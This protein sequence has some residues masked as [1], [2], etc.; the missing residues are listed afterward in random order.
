MPGVSGNPGGRPRSKALSHAAREVLQTG[1]PTVAER[2][3]KKIA[4]QAISGDVRAAEF[5]RDSSEGRPAQ[6]VEQLPADKWDTPEHRAEVD[7]A[8][9]EVYGFRWPDDENSKPQ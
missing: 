6:R 1:N 2:I 7:R 8:V 5:L 4:D 9:F 3:A